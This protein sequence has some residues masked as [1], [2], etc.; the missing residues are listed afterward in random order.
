MQTIYAL[1]IIAGIIILPCLISCAQA[2]GNMYPL[3]SK[4]IRFEEM[5]E[6]L[7][8]IVQISPDLA[9]KRIIGFSSAENLPIYALHIGNKNVSEAILVIGQHHGEEVIGV[10]VAFALAETLLYGYSKNIKQQ[11]LLQRYQ[12][13]IVPTLNPEGFRIVSSGILKTK[14]KNNRDTDKNKKLDLRTDGVDLNRNYPVFWDL[15]PETDINSPYYKG[16]E[17]ASENETKAIV[18]LAQKHN[19]VLAVFLHSSISGAYSEHIYLPARTNN[20]AL[21]QKNLA[22]AET[23]ANFTKKDYLKGNYE[24]FNGPTSEVGNARNFFFH[25]MKTPAFLVEIGGKNK[26]GQSI[27]HPPNKML[28]IIVDKNVNALLNVFYEL[29]KSERVRL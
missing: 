18:E 2:K 12:I 1:Q 19:F 9:E 4:Y 21:F 11:H 29:D 28:Q 7:D 6:K 13:W 17:P 23:Y 26:Y 15:D 22:L 8:E 5:N 10:N 16:S 20:S 25:R 14:R 3:D 27:I 24:L